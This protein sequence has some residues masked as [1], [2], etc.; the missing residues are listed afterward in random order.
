MLNEIAKI[1]DKVRELTTRISKYFDRCHEE[2]IEGI[3]DSQEAM[4]DMDETYTQRLNDIE[5][6][7]CEISEMTGGNE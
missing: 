7:L 2:S 3:T 4:C 5:E 6:A 1:Y